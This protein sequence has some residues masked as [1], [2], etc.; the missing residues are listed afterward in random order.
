MGVKASAGYKKTSRSSSG[1]SNVTFVPASG[2]SVRFLTGSDGWVEFKEFWLD[3]KPII[4]TEENEHLVPEDKWP[5]TLYL[6][7]ALDTAQNRVVAI[8]LKKSLADKIVTMEEAYS[9]KKGWE[10]TDYDL[11]LGKTGSGMDTTY[12]ALFEGAEKVDISRYEVP[13]LFAI[14]GALISPEKAEAQES[15]IETDTEVEA[16]VKKKIV[17]RKG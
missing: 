13:D 6:A 12:N 1:P 10:L 9:E 3:G 17:V 5:S 14:L 11:E 7:A 4:L 15:D 2:I 8:K 16:P